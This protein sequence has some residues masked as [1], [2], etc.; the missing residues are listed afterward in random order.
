M[1]IRKCL[2][3]KKKN[4]EPD[5][6]VEREYIFFTVKFNNFREVSASEAN[7]ITDREVFD[8]CECVLA[9]PDS[10]SDSG[11]PTQLVISCH[12]AGSRVCAE[13]EKI[14]GVAYASE[15]IKNGFAALDIN[16]SLPHGLTMGC[17]EHIFALYKAYKY[18]IRHYNLTERVLV[19]GAS[20]GGTTA[21]NFAN[22]FPSI[23]L[24]LGLFFPRLNIDGVTVDGHYCIGT[25]D[26][27]VRKA[28]DVPSTKERIVEVYRFPTNDWCEANTIGFNPYKTRSFINQNGEC[29]IFPPCPIKI[30][31]GTADTVVDP[32]MVEEYVNSI[33]RG[34]SYV[35][36]HKMEGVAHSINAVMKEELRIWFERFV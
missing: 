20:M 1:E 32:V 17:P 23:V 2:I 26:K 7:E 5:G 28:E 8:E 6:T 16:G 10:Y 19:A 13:S 22:A 31:Q 4:G 29:V 9:L 33:R 24:S 14:G 35:E 25:W 12:G 30:W 21:L 34:G 36:L 11:E 18:A 15:L 27:N 3:P